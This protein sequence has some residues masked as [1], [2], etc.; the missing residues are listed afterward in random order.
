[1]DTYIWTLG[2][3]MDKRHKFYS[4]PSIKRKLVQDIILMVYYTERYQE[5][6]KKDIGICWKYKEQCS[7]YHIVDKW[8]ST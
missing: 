6:D 4:E 2:K 5:M 8:T 3:S 1:M 7:F